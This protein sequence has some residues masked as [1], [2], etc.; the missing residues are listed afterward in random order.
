MTINYVLKNTDRLDELEFVW[1]HG[2]PADHQ[3]QAEFLRLLPAP[4]A[5]QGS[6]DMIGWR[7]CLRRPLRLCLPVAI[8]VGYVVNVG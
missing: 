3:V 5:A 7:C 8:V 6:R 4:A 1:V 2:G